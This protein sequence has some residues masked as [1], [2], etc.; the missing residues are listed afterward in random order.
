MNGKCSYVLFSTRCYFKICLF[1]RNSGTE[2]FDFKRFATNVGSYSFTLRRLSDANE[3]SSRRRFDAT[4]IDAPTK[5]KMHS[6]LV[7]MKERETKSNFYKGTVTNDAIKSQ[8]MVI[9]LLSPNFSLLQPSRYKPKPEITYMYVHT[10]SLH[11]APCV[12]Q[13]FLR[14]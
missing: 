7:F 1:L 10:T 14:G 9:S 13:R 8:H 5:S 4:A 2:Q 12:S 3:T 11:F 6:A